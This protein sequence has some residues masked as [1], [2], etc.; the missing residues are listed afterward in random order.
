MYG[1]MKELSAEERP[2]ERCEKY[3]VSALSDVEL[4]SVLLRNG[5]GKKGV[6]ELA[7][8]VLN[9]CGPG[10]SIGHLSNLSLKELR[11]IKGIGRVKAIEL[12]CL[13][14]F[15]RR[16]WRQR[17]KAGFKVKDASD[18]AGYF[19]EELRYKDEE[20]V[21]I[22]LLNAKNIVIGDFL[23]T[24]GTASSSPVAVRE[25]LKKSLTMDAVKVIL[26][27]NHPSG[28]PAPSAADVETASLLKKA[29]ALVG[30]VL[31]DSIIIG[32]GVYYSFQE[33]EIVF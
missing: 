19:M 1:L 11:E 12:L 7:A 4:L 32:D 8:E 14:E 24:R 20:N 9:R 23:M 2:Y 27:H 15:S 13:C 33:E 26:I 17:Y 5:T 22:L 18:A 25:I 31:L 30:I 3:G 16:M 10:K 28:D 21:C 6:L 29:M